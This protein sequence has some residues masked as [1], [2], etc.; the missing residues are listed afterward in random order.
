MNWDDPLTDDTIAY[1]FKEKPDNVFL[2]FI[3]DSCHSG[4]ISRDISESNPHNMIKNKY[5][6]PPS[7]IAHRSIG[8][9]LPVNTFGAVNKLPNKPVSQK[10]ALLSGCRDNQTSADAFVDGKYQGALT[11]SL[12]KAINNNPHRSLT[13]LHAEVISILNVG[14]YKQKPQLSGNPGLI[15][16]RNIFGSK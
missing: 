11:S 9:D 1:L 2:T 6:P 13:E 16:I 7:D 5:I 14:G 8:R 4:S 10:H 15:K 12:I 3:C